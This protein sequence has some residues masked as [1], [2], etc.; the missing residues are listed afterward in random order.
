MFEQK[1][2][3]IGL[4]LKQYWQSYSKII[5]MACMDFFQPW[6]G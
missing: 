2:L 5:V 6:V 3:S 4:H 1:V